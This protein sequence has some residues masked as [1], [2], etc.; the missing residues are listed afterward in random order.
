MRE[1][2]GGSQGN[3]PAAWAEYDEACDSLVIQENNYLGRRAYVIF[4]PVLNLSGR[5]AD[6]V[7]G[8]KE[9]HSS[10]LANQVPSRAGLIPSRNSHVHIVI[11]ALLQLVLEIYLS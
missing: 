1:R 7:F 4:Y 2:V 10:S 6:E 11:L 3:P 8:M 5:K 9:D